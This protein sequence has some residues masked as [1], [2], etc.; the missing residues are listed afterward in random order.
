MVFYSLAES[1]KITTH[2]QYLKDTVSGKPVSFTV[3]ATG[4]Q[5]L[6]YQWQW[7]P[8]VEGVGSGQWKNLSSGG[9]VQGADTATL[10]FISIESCSEGLYRCVVT[11]VVGE[12]I[13]KC[14]DHI[15]GEYRVVM[16]RYPSTVQLYNLCIMHE[17]QT[18]ILTL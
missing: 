11:N 10:T 8:V 1:P 6:R 13:S 15:V 7:N 17:P 3:Q 9:S 2:P 16:P 4:T 14:T 12:E 18:Y 5:P